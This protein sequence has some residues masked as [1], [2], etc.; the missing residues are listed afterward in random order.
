MRWQLHGMRIAWRHNTVQNVKINNTAT[1][2]SL[3]DQKTR[4]R[5]VIIKSMAMAPEHGPPLLQGD[6]HGGG[7]LVNR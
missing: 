6:G 7:A 4:R 2:Q 5:Q 1:A 3:K